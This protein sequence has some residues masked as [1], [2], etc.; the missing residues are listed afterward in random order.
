MKP[1]RS[2]YSLKE[3][4]PLVSLAERIKTKR[5]LLIVFLS[6]FLAPYSPLLAK[7]AQAKAVPSTEQEQQFTYYWYAAKQAIEQEQYDKALVMLEFCHLLNPH[8][9]QTL[10]YLGIMYNGVGQKD[11]ALEVYRKAFEADPHDQ[12]KRLVMALME[13]RTAEGIDEAMQ[14]MEKA[15][16]VQ[17]S[18]VD[19]ELLENLRRLYAATGQWAK[20][21]EIQD[22]IDRLKGYDANSAYNRFRTYALW[23]KP[24]KALAAVD[25]YLEQ[26]PTDVQFLLYRVELQERMRAKADELYKSYERVLTLNPGNKTV[27]NN[28]SYHLATHGGDLK[29]AERMSELTIREEPNNP[30]YLDTYGWILHLQGQNELALFYLNKALNN[31]PEDAT[32]EEIKKHIHAIK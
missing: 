5:L 28:Y 21:I 3:Q 12:W 23:N 6:L 10:T 2:Y 26:E 18:N 24:K 7:K 29:K 1:D 4:R 11:R 25:K 16:K 19:E 27:L 22:H 20:T 17:K 31:A 15:Y 8:D 32:K 13:Q 9:G 30:V 14:V